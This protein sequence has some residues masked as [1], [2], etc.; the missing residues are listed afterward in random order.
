MYAGRV[1]K[2]NAHKKC[3][4]KMFT[5]SFQAKPAKY[6]PPLSNKNLTLCPYLPPPARR[7]QGII[8]PRGEAPRP[9]LPLGLSKLHQH[10]VQRVLSPPPRP[11]L[12]I[13]S[14]PPPASTQPDVVSVM[15]FIQQY[16]F[17]P[18]LIP[19][20]PMKWAELIFLGKNTAEKRP[21]HFQLKKF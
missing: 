12:C 3:L 7:P 14:L 19:R 16:P 11:T 13:P 20:S 18:C 6:W 5:D 2:I 10:K 17:A 8:I 4:Q 21:C 9:H 15:A 1:W